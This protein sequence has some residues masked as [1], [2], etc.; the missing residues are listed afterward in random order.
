RIGDTV[1][2]RRAGDVIPEVVAPVLA[3][4]PDTAV[5]FVMPTH[6]P[7]CGSLI[8]RLEGEAVSRCTGGLVC[9]AQRKQALAHAT[10]RRAL[11]IEGLGEKLIDQL[12]ERG[13]VRSLADLYTLSADELAEYERMGAKSAQNLVEAIERAREPTL[14][15]LLFA[16]GI[17]HVGEATARDIARHFGTLSALLEADEAALM[18]VPSVGPVVAAAVAH[19]LAEPHNRE[20]LRQLVEERGVR[21]RPEAA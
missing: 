19:F 5:E 13:R 2:V 17:R 7:V 14:G 11:D 15:R 1:V 21:P 10:G 4:R 16:L 12:V 6:C 8:E 3:R 18:G 20:V 9:G